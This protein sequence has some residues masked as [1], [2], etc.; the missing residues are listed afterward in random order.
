METRFSQLK[1]FGIHASDGDIGGCQDVLIDD[2][3]WVVRYLV[4]DTNKWL[5]LSRKVVITPVSIEKV[6]HT[7][8]KL[9]VNLSQDAVKNSP[10]LEAHQPV[11]R[12]YESLLF[13]YFGYGYYWT[14]PG[15]WGEYAHPMELVDIA[16]QVHETA[17]A[18][19]EHL[20]SCE[21]LE[22]YSI[23][24]NDGKA[25][26]VDDFI[27]Q[28]PEWSVA[29]LIINLNDWLPGGKQVKVPTHQIKHIDW[30]GHSI[31]LNMDKADLESAPDA[32]D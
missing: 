2:E 29:D 32:D 17:P 13:R 7:N 30:A 21:E 15:T 31:V 19:E 12:E 5:P 24:L 18:N 10:P 22:G 4:A 26:H 8:E 28:L 14:G 9:H 23:V 6:D 27:V 25:G 20:R 16:E 11:S 1:H 3:Q